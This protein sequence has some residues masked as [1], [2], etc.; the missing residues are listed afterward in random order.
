MNQHK[1]ILILSNI[2][3]PYQIDFLQ[4]LSKTIEVKGV[5]LK[6]KEMNRDWTIKY[7][8]CVETLNHNSWLTNFLHL[9]KI[10]EDF[11]PNIVIVGGYSLPFANLIKTYS[12]LK[13]M[14]FYYWLEKPLPQFFLKKS[15]RFILK[16]LTL[17]FSKGILCVGSE[18]LYSYKKFSSN[19]L[20]FPYSIDYLK[21]K[22][23]N[24]LQ[25]G[26]KLNFLFVGQYIS[27]KGVIELLEAFSEIDP[28]RAKLNLIGSGELGNLIDIYEK[29]YSHIKNL[30]FID[31]SS[32]VLH[33]AKNDIFILPSKH[34]GWGVVIAEAMASQLAIISTVNTGAFLDL[35][36]TSDCGIECESKKES[37]KQAITHYIENPALAKRQGIFA[38]KTLIN[39]V[40]STQNSV[41]SIKKFLK[42]N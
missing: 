35:V 36:L 5:F 27:R 32:L 22:K 12:Y 25:H 30:G 38:R 41:T 9:K 21:Y 42:I 40:A 7:P 11:S 24:H 1:R 6:S 20:N 13:G 39:S 28:S 17:P 19:L 29:K 34:D 16:L 26:N 3:T 23:S 2:P 33:Y 15:V 37:I 18:A 31:Q 14:D 4:E 10:L 8:P